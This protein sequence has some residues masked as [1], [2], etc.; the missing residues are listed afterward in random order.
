MPLDSV[1]IF[2]E[3]GPGRLRQEMRQMKKQ[4]DFEKDSGQIIF[5]MRILK[6]Q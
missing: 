5:G 6:L 4:E 2:E 3:K 1:K